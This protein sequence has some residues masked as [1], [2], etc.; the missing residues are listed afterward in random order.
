MRTCYCRRCGTANQIEETDEKFFCAECGVE[1]TVPKKRTEEQVNSAAPVN[2]TP[3]VTAPQATAFTTP[4]VM[5]TDDYSAT[6]E[7]NT[8]PKKKKTGLIVTLS[9]IFVVIA[10]AAVLLLAPIKS[11]LPIR[12]HCDECNKIKFSEKYSIED[13]SG[14]NNETLYICKDCFEENG[15]EEID[16]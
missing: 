12:F 4:P 15:Y 16:D 10:A 8:K 13:G 9:V 5:P 11:F 7:T 1:N 3:Y 14:K 2:Q 6:T